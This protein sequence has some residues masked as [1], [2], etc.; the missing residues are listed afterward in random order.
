M[1]TDLKRNPSTGWLL[2][3]TTVAYADNVNL[4][5]D[6]SFSYD[7]TGNLRSRALRRRPRR[8]THPRVSGTICSIG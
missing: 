7:E 1:R 6:L 3:S 2:G 4:I 5:Q 8:R